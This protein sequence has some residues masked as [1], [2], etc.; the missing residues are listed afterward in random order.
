M[1]RSNYSAK[2][3]ECLEVLGK[4]RSTIKDIVDLGAA[5]GVNSVG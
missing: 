4:D 3:H 5:T 2:L 1:L